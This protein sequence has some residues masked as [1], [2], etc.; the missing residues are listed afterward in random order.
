[1]QNVETGLFVMLNPTANKF[2][3]VPSSAPANCQTFTALLG[4]NFNNQ[5][6]PQGMLLTGYMPSINPNSL[7]PQSCTY[8]STA[9]PGQGF[10]AIPAF[11]PNAWSVDTFADLC[12]TPA[13]TYAPA[14]GI[15]NGS[16]NGTCNLALTTA[17]CSYTNDTL[18]TPTSASYVD[19]N[20]RLA[21][22]T[23]A[24]TPQLLWVAASSSTPTMGITWRLTLSAVVSLSGQIQA[25]CATG[26]LDCAG[27]SADGTTCMPCQCSGA[28]SWNGSTCVCKGGSQANASGQCVCTGAA[29]WVGDS[30]TGNCQCAPGAAQ[31]NGVCACQGQ[32]SSWNPSTQ[33]CSCSGGAV[34]DPVKGCQCPGSSVW[35]PQLNA[36]SC[37]QPMQIW[38]PVKGCTCASTALTMQDGSCACGPNSSWDSTTKQ[39][40]CGGG[41][42]SATRN[43]D[44]TITNPCVCPSGKTKNRD[45]ACVTKFQKMLPWLIVG[46]VLTVGIIVLAKS[47]R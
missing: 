12:Q 43:R 16:S 25:S 21:V 17:Q 10:T 9:E 7:T 22:D 40:V 33:V 11:L 3:L 32:G 31:V 20:L 27:C 29:S 1:M 38:D 13:T 26:C 44:G 6:N 30:W 24:A 19:T 5:S 18:T 8:A 46:G 47:K 15:Y 23:S 36:C 42:S 34:L 41:S 28:S 2:V 35:D 37:S 14:I 4:D 45:G 39:C